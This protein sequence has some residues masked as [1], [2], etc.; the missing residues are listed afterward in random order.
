MLALRYAP[1]VDF[2]RAANMAPTK[3]ALV[4]RSLVGHAVGDTKMRTSS[5][6]TTSPSLRSAYRAPRGVACP[7]QPGPISSSARSALPGSASL[8][9]RIHPASSVAST[10]VR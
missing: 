10:T 3:I 1:L 6:S 5:P 2:S 7:G 4:L 8:R 9:S